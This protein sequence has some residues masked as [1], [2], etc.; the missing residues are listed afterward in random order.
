[1]R[2]GKGEEDA[3]SNLQKESIGG[4]Y[5]QH[6]APAYLHRSCIAKQLLF[7]DNPIRVVSCLRLPS[8]HEHAAPTSLAQDPT[9]RTFVY[10]LARFVRS[11]R[12]QGVAT[13]FQKSQLRL[14]VKVRVICAVCCAEN[15]RKNYLETSSARIE[16]R[17][18]LGPYEM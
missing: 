13:L 15:F 9:F 8:K 16:G 18:T 11:R 10:Q 14:S 17:S 6:L 4:S 1:M 2:G 7:T 3:H 12:L 5:T